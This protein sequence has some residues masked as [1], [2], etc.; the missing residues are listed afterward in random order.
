MVSAALRVR[1][2]GRRIEMATHIE[3]EHPGEEC[4][5]GLTT[6]ELEWAHVGFHGHLPRPNHVH[7]RREV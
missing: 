7:P 6:S 5:P 1:G 3:T 4:P 2:G